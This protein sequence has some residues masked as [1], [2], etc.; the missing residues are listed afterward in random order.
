[1]LPVTVVADLSPAL[2]ITE[3]KELT[4]KLKVVGGSDALSVEAQR[5]A[6]F[7]FFSLL[8]QTFASKRVLSELKLTEPAFKWIIGEIFSRFNQVSLIS[9]HDW[10]PPPLLLSLLSRLSLGNLF[11][12][13][14]SEYQ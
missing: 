6:T 3:I 7:M 9:I 10:H 13:A 4:E 5:N 8:R 14:G 11:C 12:T 1:M 2:I